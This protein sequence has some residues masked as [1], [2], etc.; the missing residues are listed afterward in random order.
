MVDGTGLEN[1]RGVKTTASSN[2]A[3]SA[4]TAVFQ[5]PGEVAS[6]EARSTSVKVRKRGVSGRSL[7]GT[8]RLPFSAP[9]VARL[10]DMAAEGAFWAW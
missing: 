5:L 9:G 7:A 4:T 6:P 8:P 3:L 2:L 1:R 10:A